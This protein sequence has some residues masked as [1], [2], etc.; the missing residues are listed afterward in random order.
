MDRYVLTANFEKAAT[1]I[2]KSK[3]TYKETAI[4]EAVAKT[5][6]KLDEIMKNFNEGAD[7]E[8]YFDL[9]NSATAYIN[10]LDNLSAV[11]NANLSDFAKELD[12]IYKEEDDAVEKLNIEE[13]YGTSV[14]YR[15]Y[16]SIQTVVAS[17]KNALYPKLKMTL[18]SRLD[19]VKIADI[20]TIVELKDG[21]NG[22]FKECEDVV[23]LKFGD[24]VKIEAEV[25]LN[26]FTDFKNKWESFVRS[27]ERD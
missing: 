13:K 25:Y 1:N 15:K 17:Q 27:F 11:F 19:G 26:G 22:K 4:F 8:E 10:I 20:I 9:L 7:D 23:Y 24:N 18:V 12:R 16:D 3:L 2:V 6:I 21:Y 5:D 14:Y